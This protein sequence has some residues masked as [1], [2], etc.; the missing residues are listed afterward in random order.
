ME[1]LETGRPISAKESPCDAQ[2]NTRQM[3][4]KEDEH[5]EQDG[6]HFPR[7][8]AVRPMKASHTA[9]F[10]IPPQPRGRP[11]PYQETTLRPCLFA[12]CELKCHIAELGELP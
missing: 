10:N 7:S 9:Y 2:Q 5:H 1:L 8:D 4:A 12:F 3:V 11:L 6:N